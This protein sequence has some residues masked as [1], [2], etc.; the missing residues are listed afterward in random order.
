MGEKTSFE[1]LLEQIDFQVKRFSEKRKEHRAKY[2]FWS[3]I[4][5]CTG[6]GATLVL[7]WSVSTE[8][9]Q[10][11]KNIA[12]LLTS[13]TTICT[14]ILSHFQHKDHYIAFTW[15]VSQLRQLRSE[16]VFSQKLE[17][18]SSKVGLSKAVLQDMHTR[19]SAILSE[20]NSD[21][22][23]RMKQPV[24]SISNKQGQ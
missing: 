3:I 7:G 8:S 6:V 24:T 16:L 21:W 13:I 11:A 23:G 1:D 15:V 22:K 19:F 18:E 12:L 2:A 4:Q 9:L 10:C 17:L 20:S 14:L 5:I